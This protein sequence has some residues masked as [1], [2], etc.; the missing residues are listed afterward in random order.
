MPEER[1]LPP[2]EPHCQFEE[3]DQE[4]GLLDEEPPCPIGIFCLRADHDRVEKDHPYV[5][6][7]S[8]LNLSELLANC[9]GLVLGC[10]EDQFRKQILGV[11][12]GSC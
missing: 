2:L 5:Y 11:E 7:N 6:P 12:S 1:E 4:E 3:E 10:I 8:I 9:Q